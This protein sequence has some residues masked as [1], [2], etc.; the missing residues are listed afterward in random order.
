MTK[1]PQGQT[2][3]VVMAPPASVWTLEVVD[4]VGT[5]I[6]TISEGEALEIGSGSGV[7]VR[8]DDATVSARHCRIALSMGRLTLTDLGSRNGIYAGGR[9][10]I[11]ET[12]LDGAG[13]FVIGRTVIAASPF[14]DDEDARE[15]PPLDGLVGQSV[16]MRRLARRVRRV[17]PLRAPVLIRGETGSGKELVAR[18]IHDLG[19]R[20]SKTFLPLNMGALPG[21]LADTELFGYERG[22]FTGAVSTRAGAFE[23]ARGGTLF[24]DE[25]AE[26]PLATQ[27]KLLRTLE[28]GEVR[29]VGAASPRVIDVRVLSATWADLGERVHASTFREDLYHRLAVLDVDVPP[30][31]HRLGDVALIARAYLRTCEIG[32]CELHPGAL[33]LLTSHSWPGNVR[34]LRNVLLRAASDADDGKITAELVRRAI[35]SGRAGAGARLSSSRDRKSEVAAALHA[36]RGNVKRTSLELGIARS[37]VRSWAR[38]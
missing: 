10:R 38:R 24:L 23:T 33:S 13:C 29:S 19:S 6:V 22:A 8:A 36:N 35:V 4:L 1:S 3:S 2:V 28:N 12:P 18:A 31:R 7:D 30:L 25:I 9:L 26:L 16:A 11:R 21:E 14:Q 15:H 32:P 17:A 34:E 27:A 37:T 20:A 5:R